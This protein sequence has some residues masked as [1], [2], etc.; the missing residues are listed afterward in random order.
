ML[1]TDPI[2][3]ILPTVLIREISRLCLT[4]AVTLSFLVEQHT[5]IIH[6]LNTVHVISVINSEKEF[7]HAPVPYKNIVCTYVKGV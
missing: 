7:L 2:C 4:S 3:Q 6:G 1:Y 5:F